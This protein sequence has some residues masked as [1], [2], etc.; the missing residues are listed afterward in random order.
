MQTKNPIFD[1]L[2]EIMTGAAGLVAGA[3]EEVRTV[4]RSRTDRLVADMDLVSREEFE[5]VKAMVVKALAENEALR[6]QIAALSKPKKK[7]TKKTTNKVATKF[8]GVK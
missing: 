1:D 3:G 5:L 6:K 8:G 2:A 4:I 7:A